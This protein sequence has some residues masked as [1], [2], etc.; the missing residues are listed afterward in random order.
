MKRMIADY[1]C[2]FAQF[3]AF[4]FEKQSAAIRTIRV[5][6]VPWNADLADAADLARILGN[7]NDPNETE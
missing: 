6:S 7:T 2:K 1:S 5:I 4:V 3:V